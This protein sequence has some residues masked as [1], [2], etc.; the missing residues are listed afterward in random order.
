MKLDNLAMFV[1][2]CLLV[3]PFTV[4]SA[5]V[6]LPPAIVP[7]SNGGQ[8]NIT[9]SNTDPNL[10]SVAGDR[11]VAINSLDGELTRQEQT[12]NG[13]V[14][15]ATLHQKSFT[16]V[17]ETERGLNFS[18]RAVPRAGA[19]RTIQLVSELRGTGEATKAWEESAPYHILLVELNRGVRTEKLPGAYQTVPVTEEKLPVPPGLQGTAEKVWVGHHLKIVRYT[20]ANLLPDA[21][22]IKESDFWQ[23]GTR[24]IMFTEPANHIPGG[25][26]MQLYVTTSGETR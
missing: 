16:F 10:F 24:A 26:R 5:P 23:P 11:V 2:L 13:G 15:I 21:L 14:I 8:A 22:S 12:A 17:V 18:I 3:S 20:V 7:L 6:S 25:G 19:G 9:I 1:S 4:L